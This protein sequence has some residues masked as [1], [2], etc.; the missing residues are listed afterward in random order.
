ML[1]LLS[2]RPVVP[3]TRCKAIGLVAEIGG[4]ALSRKA[5]FRAPG[6]AEIKFDP[7]LCGCL[8]NVLVQKDVQR[9]TLDGAAA[10]EQFTS[11]AEPSCKRSAIRGSRGCGWESKLL[12]DIAKLWLIS[13]PHPIRLDTF[14][15]DLQAI[16]L[17]LACLC[18]ILLL[19]PGSPRWDSF[20]S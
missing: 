20:Q 17:R 14:D 5:S 10:R 8:M 13:K 6:Y 9:D 12:L 11:G 19:T 18:S 16:L 7:S 3:S 4:C 2:L 1:I 15:K